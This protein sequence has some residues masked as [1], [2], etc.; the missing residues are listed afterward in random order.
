M[1]STDVKTRQSA[2][3]SGPILFSEASQK[4]SRTSQ[5]KS[6]E[7]PICKMKS[8]ILSQFTLNCIHYDFSSRDWAT[9][10]YILAMFI[11]KCIIRNQFL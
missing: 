4:F 1:E 7:K 9:N 5:L 8:R 10:R 2:L 11:G 6:K 3:T